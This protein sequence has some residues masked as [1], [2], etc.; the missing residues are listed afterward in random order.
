MRS[1]DPLRCFIDGCCHF[2]DTPAQFSETGANGILENYQ[3]Q[4]YEKIRY[5]FL[6]FRSSDVTFEDT[7]LYLAKKPV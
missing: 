1:I 2:F 3:K 5:N 6:K 4:Y 7:R